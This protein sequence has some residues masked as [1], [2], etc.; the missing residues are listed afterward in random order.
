M[1]PAGK[2]ALDGATWRLGVS[3][4][5]LSGA[6]R[7]R[8]AG[9]SSAGCQSPAPGSG[10]EPAGRSASPTC[11]EPREPEGREPRDCFA[12]TSAAAELGRG[13]PPGR[14]VPAP[15][16]PASVLSAAR[17]FTRG[18]WVR[19]V[20]R[21]LGPAWAAESAGTAERR[22]LPARRS[23]PQPR[24]EA[25]SVPLRANSMRQAGLGTGPGG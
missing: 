6:R 4:R 22:P 16:L 5:G 21:S 17:P 18:V 20:K 24:G 10:E 23:G 13:N 9:A 19:G 1:A 15:G 11:G 2:G 12:P 25:D 8:S 7:V 14:V 3:G